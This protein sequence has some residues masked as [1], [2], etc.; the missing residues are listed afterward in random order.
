MGSKPYE[1]S[2]TRDLEKEIQRFHRFKAQ[3]LL[4]D[5][6]AH[7]E[8]HRVYAL[9]PI[10]GREF[11]LVAKISPS[12]LFDS[13]DLHDSLGGGDPE[14]KDRV[15]IGESDIVPDNYITAFGIYEGDV[16]DGKPHQLTNYR[17]LPAMRSF[18]D[19]FEV[20]KT[21]LHNENQLTHAVMNINVYVDHQGIPNTITSDFGD[22][23]LPGGH[24]RMDRNEAGYI[25][26]YDRTDDAGNS[27]RIFNNDRGQPHHLQHAARIS[28]VIDFDETGQRV[29]HRTEE[30]AVNGKFMDRAIWEQYA[31]DYHRAVDRIARGLSNGDDALIDIAQ[32]AGE[33][34]P[35]FS[36]HN[37]DIQRDF[38]KQ[39][40]SR[41]DEHVQNSVIEK[42]QSISQDIRQEHTVP[43]IGEKGAYIREELDMEMKDINYN[44]ANVGE[45]LGIHY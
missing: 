11:S 33:V 26:M 2:S 6:H 7:P 8:L 30:Y 16:R 38:V 25:T 29:V 13:Q 40:F 12:Y 9:E 32:I 24:I 44:T 28:D 19:T 21:E 34:G 23:D 4:D 14:W 20:I 31:Q 35:R 1:Q 37:A 5:L 36:L 42:L 43:R 39:H 27:T 15:C 41:Y 10:N 18:G 17:D 45:E 3:D 22:I